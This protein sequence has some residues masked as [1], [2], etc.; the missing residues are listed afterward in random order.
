MS[1]WPQLAQDYLIICS[2]AR[3]NTLYSFL[4]NFLHTWQVCYTHLQYSRRKSQQSLIWIPRHALP[5]FAL[6]GSVLTMAVLQRWKNWPRV[7]IWL[8]KL[9]WNPWNSWKICIIWH[10]IK[11]GYLHLRRLPW[12]IL[13]LI[14]KT[15][16][17]G[18]GVD[19]NIVKVL[20][21]IILW[22]AKMSNPPSRYDATNFYKTIAM[23]WPELV[24]ELPL[25]WVW[26][27][28]NAPSR[29]CQVINPS[30]S[31]GSLTQG[32]DADWMAK[33]R[34]GHHWLQR[35]RGSFLSRPFEILDRRPLH[36]LNHSTFPIGKP[37]RTMGKP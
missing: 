8:L 2:H 23:W 24:G 20:H 28:I 27:G 25:V 26:P 34:I 9:F 11:K 35:L 33:W 18:Q 13:F 4:L 22:A 6:C 31:V 36:V 10:S 5:A 7:R 16:A 14:C 15:H 32:W 17:L 21:H 12:C 37:G 29:E 3:R 30:T 1:H 19:A